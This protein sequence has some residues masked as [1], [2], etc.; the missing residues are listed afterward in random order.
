MC[1]RKYIKY[2]Y[3]IDINFLIIYTYDIPITILKRIRDVEF[4]FL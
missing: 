2:I 1:G 3:L 4:K